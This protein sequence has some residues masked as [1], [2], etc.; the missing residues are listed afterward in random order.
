[1]RQ[2]PPIL[3]LIARRRLRFIAQSCAGVVLLASWQTW[4]GQAGTI[5]DQAA[6]EDLVGLRSREALEKFREASGGAA[7]LGEAL[8]LLNL[9][10]RSEATVEKADQLLARAAEDPVVAAEAEYYRARILQI[11]RPVPDL[12]AAKAAYAALI[13]KFPDSAFGQMA[14]VKWALITA[15]QARKADREAVY[16][17]IEA[18]GAGLSNLDAARDFHLLLAN[19]SARWEMP[20]ERS[21]AELRAAEKTGTLSGRI[22]GDVLV[23]IGELSNLLG[24]RE[25]A[26]AAYTEFVRLFPRD[27]RTFTLRQQMAEKP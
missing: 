1:M 7:V 5:E 3:R 27:R 18:K 20:P 25:D 23:R 12:T 16:R 21:L 11:H 24:S 22:A 14:V 19:T 15:A 8:A 6:W 13:T 10:P 26:L 17:E 9:P 2:H 4:N